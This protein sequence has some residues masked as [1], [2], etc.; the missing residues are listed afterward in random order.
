MLTFKKGLNLILDRTS[1]M[2]TLTGNNVGK[3]TMV[4]VINYCLGGK[5][6]SIYK[7][8]ETGTDNNKVKDFLQLPQTKIKLSL[9]GSHLNDNYEIVRSFKS[10]PLI[11]GN[12]ENRI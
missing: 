6:E 11:N 1:S 2:K 7:D 12:E 5:V 8:K 9:K 4:R 3:T 10:R